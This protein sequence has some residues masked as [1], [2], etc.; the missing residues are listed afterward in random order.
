L[1]VGLEE[2]ELF[3]P[4]TPNMWALVRYSDGS[5][6]GDTL[7]KLDIDL[8][9]DQGK[10]CVSLRGLACRVLSAP[11]QAGPNLGTLLMAPAWRESV[12]DEAPSA[13]SFSQHLVIFCEPD[14]LSRQALETRLAGGDMT[15][16]ISNTREDDIAAHFQAHL[17]RVFE[18]VRII[19]QSRPASPVLVQVVV[20]GEVEEQRLLAAISSLLKT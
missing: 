3:A 8:C 13:P 7:H 6:P 18:E 2:L 1:A 17:T 12:H 20:P 16:L 14:G 19:L 10:R 9:D 11:R 4:C 5:G 15:C